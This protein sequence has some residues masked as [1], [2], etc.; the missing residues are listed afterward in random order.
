MPSEAEVYRRHAEA[1]ARLVARED[2]QGNILRALEEIAPLAGLDAVELGAGTGRLTGLLARRV[3]SIVACDASP[4]MLSAAAHRLAQSGLRNWRLAVADHRSLPL[5][6]ACADLA[7]SGWSIA[8]L[9]VWGGRG[10]RAEV[11]KALREMQRTLRPGG[12]TV[13]LET[14]G[15][16]HEQPVRPKKLA[17][18]YR[19]L[20]EQGFAWRWMRTDYRFA[21]LAEAQELAGFFFGEAMQRQVTEKEWVILPECTG[22]WYSPIENSSLG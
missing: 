9:K 20:E 14:L 7:I 8:Y 1:Y 10:W 12:R 15:T 17:A 3:R 11:G 18:Y 4:H 2:Y 21:N 6:D 19:F 22:I 16:G 13:I 5:P